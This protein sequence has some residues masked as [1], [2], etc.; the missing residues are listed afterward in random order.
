MKA[1][2]LS[3]VHDLPDDMRKVLGTDPKLH[4]HWNNLT[5]LMQ[6]EWICW[7][8]TCKKEQTRTGH[9]VR[10]IEDMQRGKRR[11]CCWPGCP[12]RRENAEKWFSKGALEA[13]KSQMEDVI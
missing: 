5:E 10:M 7:V 9:L 13:A 3:A 2:I 4:L 12:H 1:N 11:P 6:N 8:I